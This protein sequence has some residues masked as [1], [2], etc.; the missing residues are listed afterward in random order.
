M[1]VADPPAWCQHDG[2]A[3]HRVVPPH[4]PATEPGA[5]TFIELAAATVLSA[6][7]NGVAVDTSGWT[8]QTGLRLPGLAA[9]NVLVVAEEGSRFSLIEEGLMSWQ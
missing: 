8:P 2:V 6:T 1:R 7:L 5:E 3:Q 9:D 4:G